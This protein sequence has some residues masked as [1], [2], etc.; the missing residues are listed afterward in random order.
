MIPSRFGLWYGRSMVYLPVWLRI[1]GERCVVIGGGEV[2][3]RKVDAL[4]A[5]GGV[6]TVVAPQVCAALEGR[7]AANQVQLE[8]RTYRAGD[9]RGARLAFAATDDAALHEALARDAAAA[10]VPLNVVDQPAWCSFI[11]PAVLR[12]G[13]LSIGVSTEG[14]SPAL[15]GRVRD[16]IAAAL[17]PE[18]E[19]AVDLLGRLRRHLQT[20]PLSCADLQRILVALAASYMLDGV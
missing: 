2:A 5:A 18:Y 16:D 17:G 8:R 20:A 11:M 3:A 14:R 10:N 9:L 19:R 1:A 6:V 7:A 13:G 15:A 12:R 4:L